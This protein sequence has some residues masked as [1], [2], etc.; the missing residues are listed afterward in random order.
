MK[1]KLQVTKNVNIE[2][3]FLEYIVDFLNSN[4][5]FPT[6]YKLI[7]NNLSNMLSKENSNIPKN[8]SDNYYAVGEVFK[9]TTYFE[10]IK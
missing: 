7:L 10:K 9:L 8:I 6:K 5:D 1:N 3:I 2:L 4:F